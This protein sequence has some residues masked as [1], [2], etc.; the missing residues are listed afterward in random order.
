MEGS[1]SVTLFLNDK[2]HFFPN[3]KKPKILVI[4]NKV[5]ENTITIDLASEGWE[6]KKQEGSSSLE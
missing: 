4:I 2:N 3:K 1:Y 6:E 5:S